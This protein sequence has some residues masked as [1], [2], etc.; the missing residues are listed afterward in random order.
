MSAA[1]L[2]QALFDPLLDDWAHELG[3]TAEEVLSA[4]SESGRV[5]FERSPTEQY[6]LDLGAPA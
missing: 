5:H 3:C 4:M 1:P 6:E 2:P